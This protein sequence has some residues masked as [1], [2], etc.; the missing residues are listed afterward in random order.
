MIKMKLESNNFK[1]SA[2]QER[3]IKKAFK[4]I[5]QDA[6][7]KKSPA[8]KLANCKGAVNNETRINNK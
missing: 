6:Q 3:T 5:I 4:C 1:F 7:N 8:L 2:I